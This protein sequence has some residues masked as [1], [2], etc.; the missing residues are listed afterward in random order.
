MTHE[1]NYIASESILEHLI[2]HGV[3][4]LNHVLSTLL[5]EAMRLER[6]RH[7]NAAPYERSEARTDYDNGFK[8][9]I[10]IIHFVFLIAECLL[11]LLP[12]STILSL[13]A[14][15]ISPTNSISITALLGSFP[16]KWYIRQ[17]R[18]RLSGKSNIK[19]GKIF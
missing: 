14:A 10:V 3:K 11:P 6:T 2:Q 13:M 17:I 18:K 15:G 9:F 16:V 1:E 12:Y 7:L 19:R 8:D 5:N 4:E